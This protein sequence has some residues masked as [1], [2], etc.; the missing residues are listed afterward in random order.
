MENAILPAYLKHSRWFTGR[1]RSV[2]NVEII[3]QVF[4]PSTPEALLLLIEVTYESGLPELYRL[5]VTF[6]QNAVAKK[7]ENSFPHSDIAHMH[8]GGQQGIL[9]DA[10]YVTTFQQWLFHYLV[11]NETLAGKENNQIKFYN[12]GTLVA[13]AAQHDDIKSKVYEGNRYQIA[14]TYDN[15]FF[16]TQYRRVDYYINPDAEITHFLSEQAKFAYIPPPPFVGAIEW[17][18]EKGMI[19]IGMVQVMVENHGNGYSYMQE[20]CTI[21]LKGILVLNQ[22]NLPSWESLGS[23]TDPVA[24]DQLPP[25]LKDLL[26]SRAAEERNSALVGM[27]PG[28]RQM[29]Q[30]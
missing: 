6:V 2:Y 26:G 27:Q 1:A 24:F 10:A 4:I 7:L 25:A 21:I 29:P 16:L 11:H 13:Y 9:C 5:T 15:N 18:T 8:I 14:V 30:R 22:E 17:I 23:L 19:T 28:F 3:N 12:N 20:R